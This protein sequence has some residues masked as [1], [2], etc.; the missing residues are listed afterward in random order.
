MGKNPAP[1]LILCCLAFAGV[2]AQEP[3]VPA[4]FLTVKPKN[5]IQKTL[6]KKDLDAA[7]QNPEGLSA[8]IRA[9]P[10][11]QE[12]KILGVKIVSV[13]E[14]SFFAKMGFQQGDLF[15]TV[16]GIPI[17]TEHLDLLVSVKEPPITYRVLRNGE[18]VDIRIESQ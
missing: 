5:T 9:V 10:N 6:A 18:L 16:N 8:Q 12:G 4:D 1:I 13:E 3:K 11:L 7:A 14:G 17:D 15:L 2:Q